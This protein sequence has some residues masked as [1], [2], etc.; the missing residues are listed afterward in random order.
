MGRLLAAPYM[1]EKIYV[2]DVSGWR[3]SGAICALSDSDR[4]L[5][6]IV[7]TRNRW[8]AFDATH[9]DEHRA[10]FRYLGV[11]RTQAEAKAAVE[12]SA[13]EPKRMS[14]A[15]GQGFS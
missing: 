12:A 11:Y 5:G 14:T 7:L 10:G 6:H 15:A 13:A 3:D 8:N 1:R 2:R 4:H 9:L